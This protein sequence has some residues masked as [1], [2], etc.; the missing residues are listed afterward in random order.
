MQA[1]ARPLEPT[2]YWQ[3]LRVVLD[4]VLD[5]QAHVFGVDEHGQLMRFLALPPNAQM[6][7]GRL[8]QRR[9]PDF[10]RSSLDYA[11][12]GDVDGAI[13]HLDRAGFV[14]ARPELTLD[15]RVA[16]FTVRELRQVAGAAPP[17]SLGSPRQSFGQ[18]RGRAACPPFHAHEA[19]LPNGLET[20]GERSGRRVRTRS[21]RG[22]G[23]RRWVGSAP[24]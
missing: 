3:N 19:R 20:M 6:L 1:E 18:V 9:G 21:G 17:R 12:I 10:R 4:T 22:R 5:A 2:Y 15:E 7:Y 11:E 13:A 24:G 16:L 8:L 14:E 23:R